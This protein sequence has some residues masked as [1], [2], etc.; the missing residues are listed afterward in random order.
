VD[1]MHAL[2]LLPALVD[3]A[4]DLAARESEALLLALVG[5][6]V[7]FLALV[8]IG[9]FIFLLGRLFAERA[10]PESQSRP[11]AEPVAADG[12]D[13]RTIAVISAAAFVAV[14][15]PV[16]VQRITFI[17]RNTISAW[18]ERGRVSIHGSHNVRRT[19]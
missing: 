1:I 10:V 14:G 12:L 3:V 6:S 2:A 7:V 15:Q 9:F 4:D 19:L 13:P 5:M 17:N 8:T 18:A 16:R 11:V